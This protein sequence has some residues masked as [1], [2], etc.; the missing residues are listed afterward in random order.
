MLGTVSTGFGF[1]A[2]SVAITRPGDRYQTPTRPHTC[3]APTPPLG[4]NFAP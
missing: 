1:A 2:A 3:W 4:L